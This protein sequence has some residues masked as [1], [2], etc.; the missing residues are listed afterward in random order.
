MIEDDIND[1]CMF[2]QIKTKRLFLKRRTVA[3]MKFVV[4]E[5][6]ILTFTSLFWDIYLLI[7][8]HLPP[9]FGTFTSSFWDI[10]LLIL[11][12]LPPYFGTFTSLFWDIYLL[13]LGHLS[14]Y[15]GTFTTGFN[16]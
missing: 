6:F 1:V 15:F 8:G 16:C 14:H 12:H 4:A 10:Y 2:S 13:I 11:G 9:Y 5:S 3:Q 7:L